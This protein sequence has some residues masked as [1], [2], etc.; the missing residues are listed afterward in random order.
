MKLYEEFNLYEK[1]WY[2]ID[3]AIAASNSNTIF[4]LVQYW[5]PRQKG[6]PE[7]ISFDGI[8]VD[9]AEA[10]DRYALVS[11]HPSL[12]N[13]LIRIDLVQFTNLSKDE[14]DSIRAYDYAKVFSTANYTVIAS[15]SSKGSGSS[16]YK[17]YYVVCVLE[18]AFSSPTVLSAGTIKIDVNKVSAHET[19]EELA[20]TDYFDRAGIVYSDDWDDDMWDY[21]T[22]YVYEI[23]A[24]TY[25]TES[26]LPKTNADILKYVEDSLA[27]YEE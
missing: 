17:Y 15:T 24:T 12:G 13:K 10:L 27:D 23:D 5:T 14:I 18:E 2:N 19:P 4:A 26:G 21:L 6:G 20:M 11:N 3:D 7:H 25:E 16:S 9:K 1:L 22:R 8:L